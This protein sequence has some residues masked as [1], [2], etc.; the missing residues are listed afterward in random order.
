VAG[1]VDQQAVV[2]A[3]R[4]AVLAERVEDIEAGCVL[5]QQVNNLETV[6]VVEEVADRLRVA[7]RCLECRQRR[8]VVVD[9]DDERVVIAGC[10]SR[11]RLLNGIK[12]SG[13]SHCGG[14]CEQ[15]REEGNR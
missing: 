15:E 9:A 5:V 1:V 12:A 10:S 8:L 4:V 14:D 3:E 6:S 11:L 2:F 7:D 13:L